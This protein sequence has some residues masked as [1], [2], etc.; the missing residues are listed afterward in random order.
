[1][2]AR[3]ELYMGIV[4]FRSIV[5]RIKYIL[6]MGVVYVVGRVVIVPLVRNNTKTTTTLIYIKPNTSTRI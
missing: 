1:M 2:R 6:Y 3:T 5:Y 4:P